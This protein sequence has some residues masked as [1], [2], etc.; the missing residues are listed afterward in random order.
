MKSSLLQKLL[1][2]LYS[3]ADL[4]GARPSPPSPVEA[5]ILSISCSFWENLAKSYVGAPPH[6]S[7]SWR[8]ILGEILDP[9]LIL[10]LRRK[11][12]GANRLITYLAIQADRNWL[13]VNTSIY[14]HSIQKIV[15]WISVVF[16]FLYVWTTL[17]C[18][19]ENCCSQKGEVITDVY[20]SCI[21]SRPCS[22]SRSAGDVRLSA[23]NTVGVCAR[24]TLPLPP[25]RTRR[26][27]LPCSKSRNPR[28]A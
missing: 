9:P 1:P 20:G 2:I 19:K 24:C 3:V 4:R 17:Q 25:T 10:Y 14:C 18:R 5:Q 27:R 28:A 12:F 8:P 6:P 15:V 23:A 11:N 26:C 22:R 13:C 7:G 21:P 16:F